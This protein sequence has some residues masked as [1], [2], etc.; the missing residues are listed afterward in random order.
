MGLSLL[1]HAARPKTLSAGKTRSIKLKALSAIDLAKDFGLR[2]AIAK[3][4]VAKLYALLR[5]GHP[6]LDDWKRCFAGILALDANRAAKSIITTANKLE[7][8]DRELLPEAFLFALQLY[9]ARLLQLLVKR[10]CGL[11]QIDVSEEP[12]SGNLWSDSKELDV[13]QNRLSAALE[14]Y[15]LSPLQ[16]VRNAS[17]DLLKAVYQELFPRQ[18]RHQLGE[19]YTPDWLAEQ[20][21]DQLGFT[22]K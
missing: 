3:H 16:Q 1:P 14:K 9:Y 17:G 2:S 22:G 10:F 7:I 4:C 5:A 15:H 19:Y 13:E 12:F 8:D 20:M 18:L 11:E 21:L 6:A